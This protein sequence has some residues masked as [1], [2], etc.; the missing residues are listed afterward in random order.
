MAYILISAY[1]DG[2]NMD[3]R[4]TEHKSFDDLVL[5]LER[6]SFEPSD[7]DDILSGNTFNDVDGEGWMRVIYV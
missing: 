3:L 1:P 5:E 7:I 4:Y 6:M 2:Y